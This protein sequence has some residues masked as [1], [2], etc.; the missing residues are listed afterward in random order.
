MGDQRSTPGSEGI[1]ATMTQHTIARTV[2][3]VKIV[4]RGHNNLLFVALPHMHYSCGARG[5]IHR[6]HLSSR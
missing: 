5:K 6:S 3:W 4:R 1:P 2:G